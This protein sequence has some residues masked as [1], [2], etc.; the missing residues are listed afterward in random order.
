[1]RQSA[2]ALRQKTNVVTPKP[3][4]QTTMTQ[5]YYPEE[6]EEEEPYNNSSL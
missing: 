4:R 3:L 6:D 1:V 2:L 5:A